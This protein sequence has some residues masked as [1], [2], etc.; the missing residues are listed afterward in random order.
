M[1]SKYKS[2]NNTSA[3]KAVIV[4]VVTAFA[5]TLLCVGI[6]ASLME[7]ERILEETVVYF[8]LGVQFASVFAGSFMAGKIASKSKLAACAATAGVYCFLL[9]ALTIL[10][11]NGAFENVLGGMI[12]IA[13]G[14]GLTLLLTFR[15]NNKST[16]RKRKAY[17]R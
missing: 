1:G 7:S 9:I 8:V 12:A 14:F 4:G 3:A 10:C 2:Q 5:V 16:L 15:K 11:F 6:I 13:L 17:S